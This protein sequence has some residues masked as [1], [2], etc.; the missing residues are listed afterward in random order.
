MK[1]LCAFG[2][3]II[4]HAARTPMIQNARY[5]C[6]LNYFPNSSPEL[7]AQFLRDTLYYLRRALGNF[8][9]MD[10]DKIGLAPKLQVW[11]DAAEFQTA[12]RNSTFDELMHALEL[13]RGAF[14]DKPIE[15][16]ATL[17]AQ[18]MDAVYVNVLRRVVVLAETM[19]RRNARWM[20]RSVG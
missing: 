10:A 17:Y 16:W 15:G 20:P 14:L 12:A 8:L 7:A 19:A 2:S 1:M 18:Q 13:Y 6:Q 11:A 3:Q 5:L 4:P 9:G